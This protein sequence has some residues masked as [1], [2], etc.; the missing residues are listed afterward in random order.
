MSPSFNKTATSSHDIIIKIQIDTLNR[1]DR[2][3]EKNEK[4]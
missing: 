2:G 3:E 1:I 4:I